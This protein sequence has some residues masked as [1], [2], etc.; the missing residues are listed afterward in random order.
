MTKNSLKIFEETQIHFLE[1]NTEST[2]K[3][4]HQT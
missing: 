1:V 3:K 4:V 2:V